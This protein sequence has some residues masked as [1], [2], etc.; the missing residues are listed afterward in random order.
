MN[1]YFEIYKKNIM[2]NLVYKESDFLLLNSSLDSSS[3]K[4]AWNY[5]KAIG[6]SLPEFAVRQSSPMDA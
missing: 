5:K 1:M 4:H 6:T 3:C 2:L